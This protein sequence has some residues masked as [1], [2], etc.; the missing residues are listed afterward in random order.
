MN[1]EKPENI[2]AFIASNLPE[3]VRKRVVEVQSELKS[4]C[5]ED[6]VRWAAPEQTHL[7]LKF[8]GGVDA[9]SLDELKAAIR[10]A[11]R[12]NAFE[13]T[14]QALGCFPNL[15]RPRVIWMGL[16]GEAKAL[17]DLQQRIEAAT[18][19]WREPEA[20]EFHPHLTLGRV[21]H[22]R[23]GELNGLARVVDAH[24]R[25]VF[26]SWRVEGLDLVRSKLSSHG[27][28]YSKLASFQLIGEV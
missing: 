24:E 3:T 8:L 28:V 21:K 17:S 27:A 12:A 26:G 20:R 7:T 22:L 25:T 1:G 9:G 5:A 4:L 16:G 15:R 6:T 2:R 18:N 14:T 11:C 19:S 13:L 23:P 10:C